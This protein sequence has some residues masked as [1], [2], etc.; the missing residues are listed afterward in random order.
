MVGWLAY[1]ASTRLVVVSISRMGSPFVC[2]FPTGFSHTC[3]VELPKGPTVLWVHLGDFMGYGHI[4]GVAFQWGGRTT[5]KI[6][7]II[8]MAVYRNP[9]FKSG[10]HLIQGNS[11]RTSIPASAMTSL[12]TLIL[13]RRNY[14]NSALL[15]NSLITNRLFNL[16]SLSFT[17]ASGKNNFSLLLPFKVLYL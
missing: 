16:Y 13:L 17:S 3:K 9:R 15:R 4:G 5:L 2:G 14:G 7:I 12:D 1:H 6:I 8:I 10:C 11:A